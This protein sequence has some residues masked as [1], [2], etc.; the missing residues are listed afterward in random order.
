MITHSFP[1][2]LQLISALTF[3]AVS[4]ALLYCYHIKVINV[5]SYVP[6]ATPPSCC[7]DMFKMAAQSNA[8]LDSIRNEYI[9]QNSAL[10][11]YGYYYYTYD[12]NQDHNNDYNN[13]N[14]NFISPT[15][16]PSFEQIVDEYSNTVVKIS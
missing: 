11:E 16:S 4:F 9:C 2:T 1:R 14:N 3:F 12:D 8:S 13:N 6:F 10:K 7:G 15:K 5:D